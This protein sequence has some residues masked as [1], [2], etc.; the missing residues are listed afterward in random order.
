MN[1]IKFIKG[2]IFTSKCQ[3]L[4]NTV[5]CVGIMG[6]GIALEFKY[7]YPEMFD[8][9]V[10]HCNN[11]RIEIGK[12]W[13]YEVP[14]SAQKVLNFPTKQ[15]WKYPSKYEYLEK[16]LRKFVETYKEKNINSIAF[17]MLGALNGG[18][19]PDKVLDLM[20]EYLDTCDIPIEVYEYEA[21]ASDD[22]I[23]KLRDVFIYTNSMTH[24]E[25]MTGIKSNTLKKIKD[26]LEKQELNS[27]IQL[28]K[29]KGIGEDTVKSCFK[30]A[31]GLKTKLIAKEQDIFSSA[32][33]NNEITLAEKLRLTNLDE[34]TIFKI[35]NK[36][37]EISIKT[38]KIYCKALKFNFTDFIAKNYATT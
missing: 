12:L 33:T 5:N 3:T 22:L 4:V 11:K 27:L 16:G 17:P 1:K 21:K 30:F 14:N 34:Q 2:N 6:A 38:I 10:E 20:H 15:H 18:L 36:E 26:V 24:L 13:V 25:K 7:R 23:D 35:E 29:I 19:D 9:Y 31:M 37:E 32:N 8:K 28:D